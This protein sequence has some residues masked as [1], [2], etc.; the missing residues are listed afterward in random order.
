MIAAH[1]IADPLQEV[2]E[3]SKNILQGSSGVRIK[4]RSNVRET[5]QLIRDTDTLSELLAGVVS[6]IDES[7][8]S[9]TETL[10][11]TTDMAQA[12]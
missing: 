2:A 1:K 9:L 12:R 7:A 11:S 4:A 5:S 6:N 8:F 3:R 10:K